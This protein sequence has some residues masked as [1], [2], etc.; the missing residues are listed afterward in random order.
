M[1]TGC[2]GSQSVGR[3]WDRVNTMHSLAWHKARCGPKSTYYVKLYAPGGN[4]KV[5]LH[6]AVASIHLF[7]VV[8]IPKDRTLPIL[9]DQ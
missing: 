1:T 5:Y 2:C 8:C 3:G 9:A 7:P 6:T 4:A